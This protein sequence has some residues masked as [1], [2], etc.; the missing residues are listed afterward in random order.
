MYRGILKEMF[1]I[2]K[3]FWKKN[4]F[5]KEIF[6]LCSLAVGMLIKEKRILKEKRIPG[7]RE[8][9]SLYDVRPWGT[10]DAHFWPGA[11]SAPG[12]KIHHL[13]QSPYKTM[14]FYTFRR[15]KRAGNFWGA[16][17]MYLARRWVDK[18]KYF[19]MT[20]FIVFLGR[21]NVDKGKKNSE[22]KRISESRDP[23]FRYVRTGGRS[24]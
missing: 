13:P 20:I 4:L 17:P 2:K 19:E 15:A 7:I 12:R 16:L 23:F 9:F 21:R 10:D 6:L 22:R 24:L 5:L 11:R 14:H 18:R 8:A 1:E 3:F